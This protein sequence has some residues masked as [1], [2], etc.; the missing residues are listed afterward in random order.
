MKVQQEG[1]TIENFKV[2]IQNLS[3]KMDGQAFA[4]YMDNLLA[5]RNKEVRALMTALKITPIYNISYSPDFNCI[6]AVF[7]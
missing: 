4:L 6:E 3:K 2:Y 1:T 7:A 5:H